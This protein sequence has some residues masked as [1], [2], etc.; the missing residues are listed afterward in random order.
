MAPQ[1]AVVREGA[2][3]A[4][5]D[6]DAVFLRIEIERF[7]D[8]CVGQK[9]VGIEERDKFAARGAD[10]GV[11]GRTD[12]GVFLR[13]HADARVARGVFGEHGGRAV[14]RAVVHADDFYLAER[15]IDDGIQ[16]LAQVFLG[17]VNGN[18]YGNEGNHDEW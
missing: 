18:D 6:A 15:L 9:V 13:D 1:L 5:A 12:A 4:A 10:A 11:A 3:A 14:R 7:V 2:D 17:V 16:A 8:G